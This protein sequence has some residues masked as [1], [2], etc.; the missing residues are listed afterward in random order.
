MYAKYIPHT[1]LL[2]VS[3]QMYVADNNTTNASDMNPWTREPPGVTYALV[4]CGDV[5]GYSPHVSGHM[6]YM[7]NIFNIR[8]CLP[9]CP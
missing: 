9:V 6:G 1:L 8:S 3:V 5:N 7:I 2:Y 4:S